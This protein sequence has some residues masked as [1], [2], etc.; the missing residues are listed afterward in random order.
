MIRESCKVAEMR[1]TIDRESAGGCFVICRDLVDFSEAATQLYRVTIRQALSRQRMM[2]SADD[3][4]EHCRRMRVSR[5]SENRDGRSSSL[6][7]SAAAV[8]DP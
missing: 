5:V 8:T 2:I 7:G 4:R 6:G 3:A 1:M